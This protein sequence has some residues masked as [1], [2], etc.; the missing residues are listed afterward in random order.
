[1]EQ[2][3]LNTSARLVRRGQIGAWL[4]GVAFLAA[5]VVLVLSGYPV[6]GSILGVSELAGITLSFI[7]KQRWSPIDA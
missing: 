2:E 5:A 6:A 3:L 4:L 7:V 1:M